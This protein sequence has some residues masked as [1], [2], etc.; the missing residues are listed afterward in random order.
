[1]TTAQTI[2]VINFIY[3]KLFTFDSSFDLNKQQMMVSIST[4]ATCLNSYYFKAF[5]NLR[6][7]SDPDTM[8]NSQFYPDL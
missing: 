2:S 4:E 8:N 1:M 3:L 7:Y 6:G 5:M